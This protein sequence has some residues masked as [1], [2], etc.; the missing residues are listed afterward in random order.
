VQGL[1]VGFGYNRKLKLPPI[2]EV[3]QFPLVRAALD[4]NYFSPPATSTAPAGRPKP[5]DLIQTAMGRLR[6]YI[7]ASLGEYW[8]AAGVRFSSF[9]MLQSFALLS[10]SFGREVE[11]GLLGLSRM[12]VPKGAAAGNEIA[13]AELALRAV[14]RPEEGTVAVE[15][16]LTDESYIFSRNCR[17]TGGFAF[18]LWS[19]GPHAGDFVVT[20]GGYHPK[21]KRLDHY[22]LVPRLGVNWQVCDELAVTAEMYFALT[23]SCLMTGGR[24]SAVYQSRNIKAWYIASID[25]LLNWQPF[26]Y[27]A[28]A[29]VSMGVQASLGIGEIV[30][31]IRAELTVQLHLWGPPF[32]GQARI[33]FAGCSVTI[34]FG[35][36]KSVPP[37]LTSE[38]F[39][40]AFLPPAGENKQ[41]QVIAIRIA[42]GLIREREKGE[43]KTRETVRAVNAHALSLTAES[44][45]PSTH[46]SGLA[47][48]AKYED[49]DRARPAIESFGIRPM[50]RKSLR[51]TLGVQLF[52]EGTELKTTPPNVQVWLVDGGVPDALWGATDKLE[53]PSTPEAKIIKAIQGVRVSFAPLDPEHPS[54][55]IP[56]QNL[57]LEQLQSGT[58]LWQD[59]GE[60]A[61]I[62][63]RGENT[64]WNTIWGN[65]HVDDNRNAILDVLRGHSPF[66]W[67]EA[68]K[69]AQVR[70]SESRYFQS[71]PEFCS[72]GAQLQ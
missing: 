30:I 69:L 43:G 39:V 18:F 13:Y 38:K 45:I 11:I 35:E 49:P 67:K 44:L 22:P 17:L 1:A 31:V 71:D 5:Q 3:H 12:S 52:R 15:G 2:E 48:N 28:D 56:L 63:A 70:C 8:F 57:R 58:V 33:D 37:P 55:A 62:S 68:P 61:A 4:E 53:L 46:F 42:G 25:F 41:S 54:T 40:A 20:L 34:P 60:P 66:L 7:P 72:L 64:F 59:L 19:A 32:S 29:A 50:A 51:S 65:E 47:E 9:E 21:F 24:L 16:R 27:Q 10:V 23:P 26:Y 6:D 14:V 36:P